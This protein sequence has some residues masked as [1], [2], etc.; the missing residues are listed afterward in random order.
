M[1][2]LA[3]VMKRRAEM[4]RCDDLRYKGADDGEILE[5]RS[6]SSDEKYANMLTKNKAIIIF[7]VNKASISILEASHRRLTTNA[8]LMTAMPTPLS[9]IRPNKQR[10][11]S[12]RL[13]GNQHAMP[14]NILPYKSFA[15][16]CYYEL[17][18]TDAGTHFWQPVGVMRYALFRR[19]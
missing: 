13:T 11:E 19:D 9:L 14:S 16:K 17:L 1:T 5:M 10:H 7:R 15:P 12:V 6:I 18:T 4:R 2:E 3:Y 8:S